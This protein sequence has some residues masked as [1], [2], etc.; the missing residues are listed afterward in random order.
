MV[1]EVLKKLKKHV[2]DKYFEKEKALN[3]NHLPLQE[4]YVA[5]TIVEWLVSTWHIFLTEG[6]EER[7][8]RLSNYLNQI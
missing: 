7:R 1:L 4:K 2:T 5:I 3:L 6:K 8:L